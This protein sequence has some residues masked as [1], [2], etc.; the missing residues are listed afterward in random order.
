MTTVTEVCGFKEED[1]IKKYKCI[2][3]NKVKWLERRKI[4]NFNDVRNPYADAEKA[5]AK[6]LDEIAK[7]T[8]VVYNFL[9]E[10]TGKPGV[11]KVVKRKGEIMY[12]YENN[13]R[14]IEVFYSKEDEFAHASEVLDYYESIIKF[15]E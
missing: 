13:K 3:D 2:V 4:S 9:L 14:E 11:K 15:E 8:G 7:E 6:E 12:V 1:G 10:K 5:S